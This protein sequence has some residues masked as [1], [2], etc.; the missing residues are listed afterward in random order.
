MKYIFPKGRALSFSILV[1][2]Q[3]TMAG[4]EPVRVDSP[5]LPPDLSVERWV[6]AAEETVLVW[7]VCALFAMVLCPGVSPGVR[8]VSLYLIL[9]PFV[10]IVCVSCDIR[11]CDEFFDGPLWDHY[12]EITEESP[13]RWSFPA[14]YVYKRRMAGGVAFCA[15]ERDIFFLVTGFVT[16][17]FYLAYFFIRTAPFDEEFGLLQ[18]AVLAGSATVLLLGTFLTIFNPRRYWFEEM[19]MYYTRRILYDIRRRE[20]A[21]VPVTL[22]V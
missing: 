12:E 4:V 20:L 10:F 11:S 8:V 17:G 14:P 13:V 2:H 3:C 5:P 1:P 15:F 16:S 21:P 6:I 22:V 9:V 7:T 19:S 18:Y